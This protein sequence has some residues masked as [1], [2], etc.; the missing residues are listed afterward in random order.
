MIKKS[1]ARKNKIIACAACCC[2][3]SAYSIT[4]ADMVY[5]KNSQ[6]I[7]GIIKKQDNSSVTLDAGYGTIT[8]HKK[9]IARIDKYDTATQEELE[10]RW[11]ARFFLRTDFLPSELS[12]LALEYNKLESARNAAIVSKAR[13]D[14][15]EKDVRA[16]EAEMETLKAEAAEVN[17]KITSL[18]PEKDILKYNSLIERINLLS[19]QIGSKGYEAEMLRKQSPTLDKIIGEYLDGLRLFNERFTQSYRAQDKSSLEQGK[20][21]FAGIEERLAEMET[22]FIK[23][24]VPYKASGSSIIVYA[25]LN[26]V[27]RASF[28]LDTGASLVTISQE[29][30]QK[31][32]LRI[33]EK[34]ASLTVTLADGRKLNAI[35]ILLENIKIGDVEAKNIPAAVL[36]SAETTEEDGLLGMSFL[37]NFIIKIDPKGNKLL[38]EQFNP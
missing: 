2:V 8:I 17:G 6:T 4:R 35:P 18:T 31:L 29:I 33:K 28:V 3:L 32:G 9:R 26:D 11:R 34:E 36:V 21:F 25:L 5:L 13:R 22:D 37:K 38:F 19:S 23:Q 10:N 14:K 12:G 24:M 7:E 30:A 16:L 15:A 27:V 1:K 20:F